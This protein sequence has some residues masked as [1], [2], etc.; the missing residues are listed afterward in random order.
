MAK[1]K[2]GSCENEV[3]AGHKSIANTAQP[4]HECP[5]QSEIN[6]NDEF[7]CNCC[8]DCAQECR[9]SI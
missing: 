4:L 2:C 3:K 9:D 8:E 5:Y 1:K 6:D 7:K